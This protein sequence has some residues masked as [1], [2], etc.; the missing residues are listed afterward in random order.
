[1][2]L[3]LL[4]QAQGLKWGHGFPQLGLGLTTC[5]GKLGLGVPGSA[6]LLKLLSAFTLLRT[7]RHMELDP[8]IEGTAVWGP[9]PR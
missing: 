9:T 2:V 7:K 1:M 8:R 3:G 5:C 6:D 4:P